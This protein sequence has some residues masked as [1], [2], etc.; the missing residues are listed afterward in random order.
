M[1]AVTAPVDA[2]PV[3]TVSIDARPVESGRTWTPAAGVTERGHVVLFVGRGEHP[4]IY[5]RFGRRLAFDGYRLSAVDGTTGLA[6]DGLRTAIAEANGLR[7]LV[8]AGSDT[9]ALRALASFHAGVAGLL[10]VG[11][12][13]AAVVDVTSAGPTATTGVDVTWADEL[14]ARSACPVHRARL[15]GDD[16]FERGALSGGVPRDLARA[17]TEAQVSVPVLIVHGG[18]DGVA[19]VA[20]ARTL[21]KRLPLAELVVVRDGR[22]DVLNDVNHRSV[23]AH[24]VAWLERLRA[25][26][27]ATPILVYEEG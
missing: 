21:A 26:A 18:A 27:A 24:V 2:A 22:H 15:D 19:P 13:T 12:P 4:G 16:A 20:D 8:F 3:D 7:P 6:A 25:D 10:L 1:T 14:D 23:A 9:G 17:A 11:S 5:E